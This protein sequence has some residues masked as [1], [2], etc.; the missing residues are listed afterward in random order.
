MLRVLKCKLY[1]N[2]GQARQL[3][4]YLDQARF[5]FNRCLEQRR[6]AFKATGKSPSLYDQ[7]KSLT[8]WRHVAGRQRIPIHVLYRISH[9]L[10]GTPAQFLNAA[11]ERK[12]TR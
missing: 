9:A 3:T 2:S 4:E 12:A 11:Y 5:I 6:D 10:G 8:T 7:H 1:P